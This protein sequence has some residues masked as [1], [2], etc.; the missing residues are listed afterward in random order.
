MRID[1]VVR[2]PTPLNEQFWQW[3]AHSRAVGT[4]GQPMTFYHGTHAKE[5]IDQFRPGDALLWRGYWFTPSKQY[6][7][8]Y[9]ARGVAPNQ[10]ALSVG[11][12]KRHV[13]PV[14]L[15][16]ENPLDMRNKQT[17]ARWVAEIKR[18]RAE[19]RTYKHWGDH[20]AELGYDSI[21]NMNSEY[22]VFDP[23]QIKSIYNQGTWDPSSPRIDL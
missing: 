20:A 4:G 18:A 21:I 2:P 9:A 17:S 16:M 3:F 8:G 1:E 22:V 15:K 5:P 7:A 23:R 10:T 6:A 11:K 19:G 12:L 13:L 14:Y